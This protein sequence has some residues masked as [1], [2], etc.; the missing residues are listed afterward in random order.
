MR[1]LTEAEIDALDERVHECID[2]IADG[3]LVVGAV[4]RGELAD[5]TALDRAADAMAEILAESRLTGPKWTM[6]D[7]ER[8]RRLRALLLS[9][10]SSEARALAAECQLS[11]A[12]GP[13]ERAA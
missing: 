2:A 9:G 4:V 1:T 7:V 11:F 13:G 6:D 12:E 5:P 3:S 8:L 10:A